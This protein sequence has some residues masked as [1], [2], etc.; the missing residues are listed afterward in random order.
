MDDED[1]SGNGSS[2]DE[3]EKGRL[4]EIGNL[5]DSAIELE[6][7]LASDASL[8]KSKPVCS[9][10]GGGVATSGERLPYRPNVH[11]RSVHGCVRQAR[12]A[13]RTKVCRIW[14]PMMSWMSS[15]TSFSTSCK[16]PP[17][18]TESWKGVKSDLARAGWNALALTLGSQKNGRDENMEVA[19][20]RKSV[21]SEEARRKKE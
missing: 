19:H 16:T 10:A 4:I 5:V 20:G 17:L 1:G 18:W 9:G 2:E 7:E 15:L 13:G 12:G 6:V 8:A 3:R 14:P 11:P 21:R